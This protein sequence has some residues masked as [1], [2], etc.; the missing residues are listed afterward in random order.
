[1]IYCSKILKY[2]VPF[3]TLYCEKLLTLNCLNIFILY[4]TAPVIKKKK[5]ISGELIEEHESMPF[6]HPAEF[7]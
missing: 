3:E 5:T 1:L 4:I 2:F 7:I 6:K